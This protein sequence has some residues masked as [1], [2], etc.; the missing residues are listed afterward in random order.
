MT[1]DRKTKRGNKIEICLQTMKKLFIKNN[2][3]D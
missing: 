2:N 1:R 3:T